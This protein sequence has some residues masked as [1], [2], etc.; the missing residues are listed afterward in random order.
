MK[1]VRKVLALILSLGSPFVSLCPDLSGPPAEESGAAAAVGT[2][3]DE[4][5]D[6]FHYSDREQ[7][8]S[9]S[10]PSDTI[11]GVRGCPTRSRVA[12]AKL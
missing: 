2:S 12:P 9:R 11:P 8:G 10:L 1:G 5:T 3:S 6:G 7:H 4:D